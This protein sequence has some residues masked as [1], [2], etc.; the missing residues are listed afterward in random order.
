M[1]TSTVDHRLVRA[2]DA[3]DHSDRK[4]RP[5]WTEAAIQHL[6]AFGGRF[7]DGFLV[8]EIREHAER[9]GFPRAPDQRAW[10]GAVVEARRRGLIRRVGY[11][12]AHDGS[13]KSVWT[14][15]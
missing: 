1:S 6:V 7:D 8:E 15:A 13:P 14:L 5:D 3:A 4:V 12:P 9:A 11:L 2:Q 10:G